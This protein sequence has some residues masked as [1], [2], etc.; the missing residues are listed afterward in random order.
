MRS[1]IR[2]LSTALLVT[3]P[4]VAY[5]EMYKVTVTRIS[6]NLYK[7]QEGLFIQTQFCLELALSEEAILKYEQHSFDNKL[8]FV[9]SR[10]TCDVK[11]VFK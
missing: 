8:I 10:T 2:V 9:S 7:T 11:K 4:L 3:L 1:P 6:D 5:A